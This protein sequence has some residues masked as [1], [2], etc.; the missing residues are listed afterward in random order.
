MSYVTGLVYDE[1]HSEYAFRAVLRL[2]IMVDTE[3]QR[4]E[5]EAQV[6]ANADDH[7]PVFTAMRTFLPDLAFTQVN[8]MFLDHPEV[9]DLLL[10][11]PRPFGSS[12]N[13]QVAGLMQTPD[14]VPEALM[15]LKVLHRLRDVLHPSNTVLPN[16]QKL[17]SHALW[18]I[19]LNQGWWHVP[20]ESARLRLLM[21]HASDPSTSPVTDVADVSCEAV[22]SLFSLEFFHGNI[23]PPEL[24]T[25]PAHAPDVHNRGEFMYALL[26]EV[27]TLGEAVAVMREVSM[28]PHATQV[29]AVET[30]LNKK[31]PIDAIL[32]AL[33]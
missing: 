3:S 17:L 8:K 33:R 28:L 31:A 7:S 5:V 18:I 25:S 16:E 29:V 24:L 11:T 10:D 13:E 22:L 19:C 12:G 15:V 32:E 27:P 2:S 26:H 1:L 9:L 14:S 23:L 21:A 20:K 6:A 30:I 4:H